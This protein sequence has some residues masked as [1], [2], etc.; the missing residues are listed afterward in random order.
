MW[1]S[2]VWTLYLPL[3]PF[4]WLALSFCLLFLNNSSV[5]LFILT[6]LITLYYILLDTYFINWD[7][8]LSYLTGWEGKTEGNK[9]EGGEI[10]VSIC[11]RNLNKW[12]IVNKFISKIV[13]IKI[14]KMLISVLP[15]LRLYHTH[16]HTYTG[17]NMASSSNISKLHTFSRMWAMNII[18]S[19]SQHHFLLFI[20]GVRG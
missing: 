3:V 16:T 1:E 14:K 7:R 19:K 20:E 18:A 15:F 8:K 10:V 11:L 13:L 4:L 2:V 6:I 17:L 9:V 12:F 5:F